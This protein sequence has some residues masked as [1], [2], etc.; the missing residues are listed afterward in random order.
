MILLIVLF[1]S[2][3]SSCDPEIPSNN[4]TLN[5]VSYNVQN[6]FDTNIDG[7]EYKEYQDSEVWNQGAYRMR[8]KT[9]S[10]IIMD[11]ALKY[12]DILVLQE[13]ENSTVVYDL[14]FHHLAKKGY[15]WYAVA[16][17]ENHATGVAVISRH[18]ITDSVVHAAQEG[19]PA[20]EATVATKGGEVVIF[21]LHAKSQI[22]EFC[23]TEALRIM[24]AR[25]IGQASLC[26]TG[27]L[28]L[29]CGDFNEDPDAVWNAD[30]QQTALVD[31]THPASSSFVLE[32]SLAVSGNT[33]RIGS[34][35]WYSPYLDKSFELSLPGSGY[36]NGL[37]HRYDQILGNG[38]MFDGIGWEYQSFG[39]CSPVSCLKSDGTPN[40]WDLGLKNGV[41]D[42]LPVLLTLTRR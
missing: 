16:K 21:A 37:W 27:K 4:H 20:L 34:S 12:P 15:C 19:R 8:L 1:L 14:L 29:I 42:H 39:V 18:P 13:I 10:K 35:V 22:G 3:L 7:T 41:S 31:I 25:A 2:L 33:D 17:S 40:G 26:Q 6:L 30:G 11:S 9:L 5:V 36:W 28:I 23:E 38:Y 24:L 32:G